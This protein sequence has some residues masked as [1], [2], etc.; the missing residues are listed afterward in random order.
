MKTAAAKILVALI[1][2]IFFFMKPLKIKNKVSMFSRQSN[3]LS[4]DFRI[5]KNWIENERPNTEICVMVKMIEGHALSYPFHIIRQLYHIATSRLVII[6]G[7]CIAASCLDHKEETKVIQIWHAQ[8]A[9]KRFGWQTVGKPSG[10]SEAI[11]RTMRM[12]SNY[13]YV[14][15]P[16]RFT[17]EVFADAMKT[18]PD[19]FVYSYQPHLYDILKRKDEIREKILKRYD[20]DNGSKTILYAPTFRRNKT[21]SCMELIGSLDLDDVNF[22]FKPHPLDHSKGLGEERV[23]D[24]RNDSIFEL[25]AASDVVI[26]DY[27]SIIVEALALDK[28]MYIYDYDIDEYKNDPGLNIEFTDET[29]GQYVSKDPDVI[30]AMINEEYDHS[31][32]DQLKRM[33]LMDEEMVNDTDDI[34]IKKLIFSVIDSRQGS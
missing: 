5:I 15:V 1:R 32:M 25:I 2:I 12:H 28:E 17:M 7:Y 29:C 4:A 6:D 19:R 21:V 34:N 16:S 14:T 31:R 3:T 18:D 23:I 8:A 9:I 30:C 26:T 20:I 27:S 24:A 10:N 33:L 11:A 22:I 13:D